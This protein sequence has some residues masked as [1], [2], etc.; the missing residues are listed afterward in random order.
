MTRE[1]TN[2]PRY[3]SLVVSPKVISEEDRSKIV[4]MP[5]TMK[6]KFGVVPP[7]DA[8]GFHFNQNIPGG[9]IRN[10]T[11]STKDEL[12][13]EVLKFRVDNSLEIGNPELEIDE[14]L[15]G[16]WP[17]LC[18]NLLPRP[19]DESPKGK[20]QRQRTTNWRY[21]RYA[22]AQGI[23]KRESQEVADA[24]AEICAGCEY[25]VD[26]KDNCSPCV[27]AND[28]ALFVLRGGKSTKM[29]VGGCAI[30]GQDNETA[31]FLPQE[32]LTYKKQYQDQL[33][34]YCWLKD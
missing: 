32:L 23:E 12:I 9:M 14:Y 33:P 20:T 24:R 25:N 31:A 15:C 4:E 2:T 8:G 27:A 19:A 34:S 21:N 18:A 11:A 1:D 5:K 30:L 13:R 17:H 22:Q 10:I 26:N 16:L 3:E 29:K 28:K 7:L 6:F